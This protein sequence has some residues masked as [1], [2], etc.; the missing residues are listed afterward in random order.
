VATRA[1]LD[2]GELLTLEGAAAKGARRVGESDL[3]AV[4]DAVMVCRDG[5]IVWTGPRVQYRAEN[6]GVTEQ[7]SLEGRTVLPGFVECHTHLV[8]AGHRAHEFEWRM[9]G[10]TYQEI[11]AKGGG[12]RHTVNE[13][14]RASAGQLA[15]LAQF[16]A[17]R[18]L[19]QGVTTLE[20]KSGYGLDLE[21]ERRCLEVARGLRGPRVVT[22]YLGA[23]SRPP[24]HQELDTYVRWMCDQ[25]LPAIRAAGLADRV[26]IYIEHGFFT[27]AHAKQYLSRA[28]ELG[29]GIT[30]HVEQL[31]D[32]GG[33]EA[34]LEFMPQ[35]LDHLVFANDAQIR[36][37]AAAET[38]AVLLP[39]SDL[40]LRMQYP[41]ARAMIDGGVRVALATDFN[42]GTSPTQ[43]L[44]LIGVLARVQMGMTLP[45]VIAAYTI[46]AAL[47]LGMGA[48]LGSLEE[49]KS[50]DFVALDCS[51]RELFYSV[52][53]HPVARVYR[54]GAQ[55]I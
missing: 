47:A 13:T 28:R 52:G 54:A 6:F 41:R 48:D 18:F 27:P 9:Q 29:F 22:T 37:L 55:L 39:A 40:Y 16:R 21:T 26:D 1:F 24:E 31:S 2:I 14:R 46:G 34:A 50:C 15:A 49:G 8:F 19:R 44:S 5:K 7:T 25:A 11:S 17:D 33:T 45:E 43:D 51:W 20:I 32:F 53:S 10:Q 4:S 36:R 35:S 30:A 38:A 42:P 3:S 12:I 23:H